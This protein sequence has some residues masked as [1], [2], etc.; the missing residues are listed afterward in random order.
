[1]A[2]QYFLPNREDGKATAF[3]KFRDNIA[4]Y[5]ATFSLAPADITQQAADATY[6]RDV[7]NFAGTMSAAGPQ[8]TAWKGIVLTGT[9]GTE[10]VI[11]A[12]RVGFPP[13]VPPGILTRFL[14]LVNAIKNHKNYT[15]PIGKILGLEGA[16]QTGPDMA[17]I[18]PAIDAAISGNHVA[19]G[20]GWGGNSA[21]LDMLEIQVDR[22]DG[23]G[24]NFLTYDTTPGYNDTAP[25]PAAPTKWT[26]KAIYRVG[27][28]QVGVW[29]NLVSIIVGG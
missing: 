8:W 4:P 2:Q 13:A 21:Y 17:T 28:E 15:V 7:L 11:P 3:E 9:T 5:V 6:F 18:Q 26:Y 24:F 1:M 29:S 20:W 19:I 16:E 27:D 25:F 10:P 22:G 14:F 12:K 23:K